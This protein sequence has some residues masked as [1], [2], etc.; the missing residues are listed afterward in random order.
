MFRH[1]AMYTDLFAGDL[2]NLVEEGAL[3][4]GA[5]AFTY[6]HPDAAAHPQNDGGYAVEDFD[7][8]DP[9][10]GTNED[11]LRSPRSFA[12]RL[13][14]MPL[15]SVM[16]HTASSHRRYYT[17]GRPR[18]RCHIAMTTAP[19]PISDAVVPEVPSHWHPATYMERRLQVG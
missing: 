18:I 17:G 11:R 5:E 12:R 14:T 10:L 7:S 8:V 9:S 19:S 4:Q 15:T 16:N 2:K 6:L 13:G 3:S 1:D